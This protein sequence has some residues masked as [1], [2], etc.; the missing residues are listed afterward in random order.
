[1]WSVRCSYRFCSSGLVSVSG[2]VFCSIASVM[3]YMACLSV[4]FC[5]WL[6]VMFSISSARCS[7][8]FT[9]YSGCRSG[10]FMMGKSRLVAVWGG[11]CRCRATVWY[12]VQL[13]LFSIICSRVS[14][15]TDLL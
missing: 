3:S 2:W 9:R 13:C 15:V 1:M 4:L 6:F 11:Q 5:V 8:V 10:R 14:A 12:T 7:S